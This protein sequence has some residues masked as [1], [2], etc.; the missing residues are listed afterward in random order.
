MDGLW[1]ASPPLN[2]SP[3]HMAVVMPQLHLATTRALA[4]NF[5]GFSGHIP[6]MTP[7][8]H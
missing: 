6:W 2:R 1:P 4:Q 3:L 7:G 5:S 8:L